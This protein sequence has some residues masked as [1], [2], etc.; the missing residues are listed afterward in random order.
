MDHGHERTE[1]G[2]HTSRPQED[3]DNRILE[4][5][6]DEEVGAAWGSQFAYAPSVWVDPRKILLCWVSPLP[7]PGDIPGNEEATVQG[8]AFLFL[9]AFL[10]SIRK[11]DI[12][13]PQRYGLA[14]FL[15]SCAERACYAWVHRWHPLHLDL[16]S[17]WKADDL[18][19]GPW[20]LL[21]KHLSNHGQLTHRPEASATRKYWCSG[22]LEEIRHIA[23]HRLEYDTRVIR[24]VVN[25]AVNINNRQLASDIEQVLKS[26]YIEECD[27]VLYHLDWLFQEK[28]Q[29][30]PKPLPEDAK[31][32]L[33]KTLGLLPTTPSTPHQIL[34]RLECILNNV[35]F[36][37]TVARNDHSG[38]WFNYAV[39]RNQRW[40]R[41][42]LA[43]P[44]E[45][46]LDN[47]RCHPYFYTG[48]FV[49]DF[50]TCVRVRNRLEHKWG[51]Y[52]NLEWL[53][54]FLTDSKRFAAVMEDSE[55][56]EAIEDLKNFAFPSIEAQFAAR[57]MAFSERS[58]SELEEL[59]T[60]RSCWYTWMY[61]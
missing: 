34:G 60:H 3:D 22:S 31:V 9:T 47:W 44:F 1:E 30:Q 14:R 5:L 35:C 46:E 18:E 49:S 58:E 61:Y 43:E 26:L 7:H 8:P 55:A 41:R 38:R 36:N 24:C 48:E 6:A 37:Y 28:P 32:A 13:F 23:V 51:F 16:L 53:V 42:Q 19:L 29:N 2:D 10:S 27:R 17:I 21:V 11:V 50:A 57:A 12:P 45:G 59:A 4:V 56:V 54:D 15:L 33:D 25:L 52:T 20:I 39:V 40:K